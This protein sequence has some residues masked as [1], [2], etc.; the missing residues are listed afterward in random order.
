[1]KS[2]DPF[3]DIPITARD[4][5]GTKTAFVDS[6]RA[7]LQQHHFMSLKQKRT[8][9]S[10]DEVL[11][12]QFSAL[13]AAESASMQPFSSPGRESSSKKMKIS[14]KPLQPGLQPSEPTS[15]ASSPLPSPSQSSLPPPSPSSVSSSSSSH[16][17]SHSGL[18]TGTNTGLHTGSSSAL[19]SSSSPQSSP[20]SAHC[21]LRSPSFPQPI[22]PKSPPSLFPPPLLLLLLPTTLSS[23]AAPRAA[24]S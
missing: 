9:K 18:H 11:S 16:S 13:D 10:P 1:M 23:S 3:Y 6:C 7:M 15:S 21:T 24:P 22:S 12:G 8:E 4:L 19:S 2:A 17:G 5:E 20:R 14:G